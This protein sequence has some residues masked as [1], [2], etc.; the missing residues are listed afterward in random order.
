EREFASVVSETRSLGTLEGWPCGPLVRGP[1]GGGP[2]ELP[3]PLDP[4]LVLADDSPATMADALPRW[5]A[6]PTRL[7]NLGARARQLAV[8]RYDWERVV[9][10]LEHVCGE[11]VPPWR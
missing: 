3:E 4:E 8:D 9:D 7:S 11:V 1:P 10:G 2:P 5:L 6:D